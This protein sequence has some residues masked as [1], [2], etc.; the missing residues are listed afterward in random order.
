MRIAGW[1]SPIRDREK[2]RIHYFYPSTVWRFQCFH[3]WFQIT[4]NFQRIADRQKILSWSKNSIKFK[5]K[6]IT[7]YFRKHIKFRNFSQWFG[8]RIN[9]KSVK[10][11]VEFCKLWEFINN[12]LYKKS[13]I[14]P[15]IPESPK[16]LQAIPKFWLSEILRTFFELFQKI[17]REET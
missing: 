7:E 11:S 8:K 17:E 5:R 3:V 15:N 13:Y 2:G 1:G 4:R 14:N 16:K 6:W 10:F 12:A 9:W